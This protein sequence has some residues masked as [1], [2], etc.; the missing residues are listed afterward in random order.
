MVTHIVGFWVVKSALYAVSVRE[1]AKKHLHF[2][3]MSVN[4][5][6]PRFYGH[7]RKVGVF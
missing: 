7:F 2:T 1:G 5:L 6:T 3:D 4:D